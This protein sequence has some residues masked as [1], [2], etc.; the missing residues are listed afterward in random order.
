MT[1]TSG[2]NSRV[3]DVI[4]FFAARPTNSFTL[5]EL[6]EQ[7]DISLGSAHRVLTTLAEARYLSRHPKHKTYSLGVALV[8]IGQAALE[9]HRSIDIA[10]REMVRLS[11]ELKVQCIADA[12]VD[13]EML[14]LDRQGVSQTHDGLNH[15]GERLPF[16]P[17]FGLGHVAWASEEALKAYLTKAPTALN[18]RKLTYLMKALQRIRERGYAIAQ[19]GPNLRSLRQVASEHHSRIRDDAH[20]ARMQ[21][22]IGQMS[23]S[24]I[25]LLSLDDARPLSISHISAPVFSPAGEIALELSLTGIPDNLDAAE[26]RQVAE[27]LRAAAAMITS[28][29]HG[30]MPRN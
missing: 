26:I 21:S 3:I 4:N 30:R 28:E 29:T 6:A 20:W 27:R 10:R 5:S 14:I 1:Y 7:L 19:N 17:P 13:G 2:P 12:I 22:L 9:K 16:I 15:I 23:D 11:N 8:A 25:Q 24:E 18:D